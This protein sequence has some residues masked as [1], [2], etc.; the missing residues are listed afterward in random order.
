MECVQVM[1]N[2]LVSLLCC[3]DGATV[4]RNGAKVSFSPGGDPEC[5]FVVVVPSEAPQESPSEYGKWLTLAVPIVAFLLLLVFWHLKKRSPA[6]KESLPFKCCS[7]TQ[8][9][10]RMFL[11]LAL[12]YSFSLFVL[13]HCYYLEQSCV[14]AAAALL[15]IGQFCFRFT[16]FVILLRF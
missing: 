12:F 15:L 5:P 8:V 16:L 4:V 7:L 14:I 6:W 9:I 11:S 1:L 13:F 3:P 2:Q 10:F